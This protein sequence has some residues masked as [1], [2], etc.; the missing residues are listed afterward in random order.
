MLVNRSIFM[1]ITGII[2]MSL[3]L[4]RIQPLISATITILIV[5]SGYLIIGIMRSKKRLSLLDDD[6]DPEAFLE[7]T[8]KQKVIV[9]KNL[10]LNTYLDVDKAAGL[11]T[12]GRFD[13]ARDILLSID[14]SKLSR[15]NDSLLVYEI[16]LMLCYYEL[17]ETEKAEELFEMTIPTLPPINSRIALHVKVLI[18]ERCFYL[19]RYEESREKFNQIGNKKLSKRTQLGI[20]YSLAQMDEQEGNIEAAVLKYDQVAVEG[21]KLW[22]AKKA[23]AWV[24]IRQL[25]S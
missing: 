20:L 7:R 5:M 14:K 12:L 21:N 13:E 25:I 8:E 1:G 23:R 6:C 10:K 2:M 4:M 15:K 16:N 9:G 22:I 17:G 19:K 24:Q 11:I 3:L 18:A